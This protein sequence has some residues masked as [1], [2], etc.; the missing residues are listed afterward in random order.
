MSILDQL[1]ANRSEMTQLSAV[2]GVAL[3]K[4]TNIQ[5]PDKL[6]RV[7]CQLLTK[8]PEVK[9]TNW[10][11][12]MSFMG[13]KGYGATFFPDVGDVVVLG[14]L[15]GDLHS[16]VVLGSVWTKEAAGPYHYQD[17]KNEIRSIRTPSGAELLLDDAKDKEKISI[18]TKKGSRLVLDDGGETLT[19]ADKDGKNG[20]TVALKNGEIT[21]RAEKK[22]TLKAGSNAAVVLDG[23][24]GKVSAEGKTKLELKGAQIGMEASGHCEIKA[25]GQLTLQASGLANLKG[26][27]VKIN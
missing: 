9:E 7:R 1:D 4:V 15:G 16:P 11:W 8:N 26:S 5:D 17:G 20:I 6:D 22:I 25:S 12:V 2:P 14:F 13:G 3:A 18:T 19:F 27:M 10:A 21:I 23:T 24:G